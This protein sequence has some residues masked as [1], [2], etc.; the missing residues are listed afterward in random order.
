MRK[1][2]LDLDTLAVESF[3]AESAETRRPGTVRGH[4]TDPPLT[5]TLEPTGNTCDYPCGA[6]QT[7]DTCDLDA[8]GACTWDCFTA[9]C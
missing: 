5:I 2:K 1:L 7:G 8:A 9:Y 6:G 3:T 4:G